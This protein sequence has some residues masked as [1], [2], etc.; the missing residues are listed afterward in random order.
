MGNL[1]DQYPLQGVNR[2]ETLNYAIN[3]EESLGDLPQFDH[4]DNNDKG[5]VDGPPNTQSF[6][7]DN[8]MDPLARLFL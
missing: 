3:S 7:N 5:V 2:W 4:L 6:L 8:L 1:Y